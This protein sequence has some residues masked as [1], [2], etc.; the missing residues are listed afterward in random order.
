[1]AQELDN[2]GREIL[3]I[4]DLPSRGGRAVPA[5]LRLPMGAFAESRG[6][7][8]VGQATIFIEGC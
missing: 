8:E 2:T 4:P 6:C 3:P 5:L 7:C 1:M